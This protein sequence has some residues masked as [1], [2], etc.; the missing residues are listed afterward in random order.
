MTTPRIPSGTRL[1]DL[2]VVNLGLTKIAAKVAKVPAANLFNTLGLTGS[3]FQAWLLYSGKLMPGG[4][5]NR[6]DTETI[7]LR[8]AHRRDCGYELDHHIRIGK[9]AGVTAELR[10]RIFEGPAAEGLSE[11]QRTI[12]SSVDELLE[13]KNLSDASWA[14]LAAHFDDRRMIEFC[15]LVT[16]YDGLATVIG[17]LRI[18]R[19]FQ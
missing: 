8:V 9:R 17:T 11:R 16:Q 19:D 14:S 3:L 4:K 7:I 15:L 12:L 2:G 10:E 1:K 18:E 5:I 6:H 13:T